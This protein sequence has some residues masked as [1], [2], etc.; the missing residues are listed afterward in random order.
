M[1]KLLKLFSLAL[2]A[3]QGSACLAQSERVTVT[4]NDGT[5]Q[6]FA[7]QSI[8]S[9][10]FSDS[11]AEAQAISCS[12]DKVESV[13]MQFTTM[14]TDAVDGY[15]VMYLEKS[16]FDDTYKSD[17]EVVDDDLKYFS[18]LATY[19]GMTLAEVIDAFLYH[20]EYTEWICGLKPDTDYVLWYYGLSTDGTLTS[21]VD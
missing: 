11:K 17:K 7:A 8:D 4:L 16:E 13:Y 10:T 3:V 12:L 14:P 2:F 18:E 1:Q 9:I 5:S 20:G 15:N 21:V 6:T 19:Y